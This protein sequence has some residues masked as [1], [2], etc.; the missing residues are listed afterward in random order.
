M[1]ETWIEKHWMALCAGCVLMGI[2]LRAVYVE[3][4]YMAIGSEWM[5][6]P[7]VFAIENCIKKCRRGKK[8]SGEIRRY[9]ERVRKRGI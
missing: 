6:I 2:S 5:I 8:K 1:I 3:R 9:T 4:G 7:M